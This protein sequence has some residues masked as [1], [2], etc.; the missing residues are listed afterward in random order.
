MQNC[1]NNNNM[2]YHCHTLEVTLP[3][4]KTNIETQLFN[5]LSPQSV[6]DYYKCNFIV[7]DKFT[8]Y[9]RQKG[10]P[11]NHAEKAKRSLNF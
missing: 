10:M 2:T 5:S 9:K 11:I 4:Y 3:F 1:I 6:F 8:T 7:N